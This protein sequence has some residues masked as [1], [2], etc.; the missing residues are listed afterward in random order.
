MKVP[1]N[2]NIW[3]TIHVFYSTKH[4][5][6]LP[7]ETDKIFILLQNYVWLKIIE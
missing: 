2:I 6:I 5:P 4:E 1:Q 3:S 7:P